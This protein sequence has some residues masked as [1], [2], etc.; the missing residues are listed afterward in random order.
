MNGKRW[1]ALPLALACVLL[2]GCQSRAAQEDESAPG[3]AEEQ[4]GDVAGADWR[5]WGTVSDSGALT[6]DGEQ[7]NVLLCV[8]RENAML[9]Y[10]RAEQEIFAELTYPY[11]L[12]DAQT[13]YASCELTD[14]NGDGQDDVRLTFLHEGGKQTD[15]VWCRDGET[16]VFDA[17]RS[18]ESVAEFL[19]STVDLEKGIEKN[20]K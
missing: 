6:V 16:F 1:I 13:A 10:D 14:Q 7:V 2:A 19:R 3:S 18:G 17:E 12:E 9:Y 20:G 15:F 4:T 11:A 8:F 5:T